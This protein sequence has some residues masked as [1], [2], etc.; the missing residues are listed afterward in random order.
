M[1]LQPVQVIEAAVAQ[2]PHSVGLVVEV[3][4]IPF[5]ADTGVIDLMG[6]VRKL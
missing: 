1:L 4:D 2:I 5:V 6:V 3:A